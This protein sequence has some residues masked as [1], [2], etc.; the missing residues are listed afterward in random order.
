MEHE[1][2]TGRIIGGGMAVHSALGPGFLESVYQRALC[3]E[4]GRPAWRSNA[5]GG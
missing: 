4:L 2:L 3:H 5:T 1:A